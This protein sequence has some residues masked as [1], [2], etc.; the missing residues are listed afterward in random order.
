MIYTNT[1]LE[2]FYRALPPS[3]LNRLLA[4]LIRNAIDV[5]R[6][7]RLPQDRLIAVVGLSFLLFNQEADR[8]IPNRRL[9]RVL[10]DVAETLHDAAKKRGD[11]VLSP[12]YNAVE[13]AALF[14]KVYGG[15]SP[16]LLKR[17]AGELARMLANL[18]LLIEESQE[19][20]A[21]ASARRAAAKAETA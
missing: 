12:G 14:Q 19:R 11:H 6:G 2:K 20:I 9:L 1:Q 4:N 3:D 8:P 21:A 13:Y 10:A 15:V 16:L 7:H 5:R 17:L 18:D